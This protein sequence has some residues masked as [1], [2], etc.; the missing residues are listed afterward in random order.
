MPQ[1]HAQ[2]PFTPQPSG[3]RQVPNY[4]IPAILVTAFCCNPLGIVSIVFAAI[5]NTLSSLGHTQQAVAN[6]NKAKLWLF[7]SVGAGVL[8]WAFLIIISVLAMFLEKA[9]SGY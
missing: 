2:N 6:S 8:L 9:G 3:H 1:T 4:L 7:V 5:A